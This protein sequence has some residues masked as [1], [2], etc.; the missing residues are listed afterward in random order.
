MEPWDI[1]L[2]AAAFRRDRIVIA[3]ILI[4]CLILATLYAVTRDNIYRSEA[5]LSL[6][7]DPTT[8]QSVPSQLGLAANFVGVQIPSSDVQIYP[9]L[10]R[11]RSR[12]F[13]QDFIER[14]DLFPL[15]VTGYWDESA[16]Q[17]RIDAK[18]Y[19]SES[20]QWLG[21]YA[22]SPPS[23]WDAYE[24]WSD[25]L[26][27]DYDER[28]GLVS[29]SLEW[30][31]PVKVATWTNAVI[32]DINTQLKSQDQDE[33]RNAIKYLE[34]QLQRTQLVEMRR[35]LNQLVESQTRTLM[36]ADIRDEYAFEVIDPAVVSERK[37]RPSRLLIVVLG[38]GAGLLL[39]ML[40][41]L[42]NNRDLF[43][44]TSR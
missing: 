13:A 37:V 25:M 20:Q 14:H 2:I 3:V 32:E 21:E 15:I 17:A 41:L 27:V 7:T 30:I 23:D 29:L 26:S 16:F 31:D 10:A 12:E 28:T 5:V 9:L 6:A 1:K 11:I 44:R 18:L 43:E 4:L 40:Y 39:S 42:I 8:E 36:L 33:A 19:D 38:L 35:A 34:E 22:D 24:I